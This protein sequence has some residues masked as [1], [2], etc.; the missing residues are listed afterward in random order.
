MGGLDFGESPRGAHGA[1]LAQSV[2]FLVVGES[3]VFGVP[4]EW[5]A[6]FDGDIGEVADG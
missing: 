5:A 4:L 3:F 1:D 2:G 6:E